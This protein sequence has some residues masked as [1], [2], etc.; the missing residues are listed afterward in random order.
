MEITFY[1]NNTHFG[2]WACG[3]IIQTSFFEGIKKINDEKPKLHL[4]PI[5][6]ID[7]LKIKKCKDSSKIMKQIWKAD[8]MIKGK[9]IGGTRKTYVGRW[10]NELFRIIVDCGI[11][12]T[13]EV[14]VP[15]W[16]NRIPGSRNKKI[17]EYPEPLNDKYQMNFGLGDYIEFPAIIEAT[18]YGEEP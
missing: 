7:L 18:T 8:Y 3:Y 16:T 5:S 13:I 15:S 4:T 10:N 9:V 14:S 17:N 11:I 12:L 2:D 1:M 6:Q